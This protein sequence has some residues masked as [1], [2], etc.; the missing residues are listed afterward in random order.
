MKIYLRI[1]FIVPP[2]VITDKWTIP[3]IY[4]TWTHKLFKDVG[5]LG[6][7][8]LP[9]L[10]N[11]LYYCKGFVDFDITCFKKYGKTWGFFDGRQPVLAIMDPETIKSVLVK[12]C[13]SVFTNHWVSNSGRMMLTTMGKALLSPTFTSGKLKEVKQWI[14]VKF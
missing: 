2:L 11:V 1:T 4:G 8:P 13:Y 3:F 7:A 12:E 9:F 5:I 14:L 10:G 6:P